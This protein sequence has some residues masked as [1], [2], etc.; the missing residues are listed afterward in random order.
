GQAAP[1][2][3]PLPAVPSSSVVGRSPAMVEV[4]GSQSGLGVARPQGA[5]RATFACTID[6]RTCTC[7]NMG[8][9]KRTMSY[10]PDPDGNQAAARQ[11]AAGSAAA[12][13]Y[14]HL[15]S[16]GT[17]AIETGG[18]HPAV[19]TRRSDDPVSASGPL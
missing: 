6:A 5:T 17:P 3:A 18:H 10:G 9:P 19:R 16:R 11:R 4:S 1:P 7:L 14:E 8:V 13:G 15:R 12:G 2:L